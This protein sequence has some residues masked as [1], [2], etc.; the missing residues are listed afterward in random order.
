MNPE[1]ISLGTTCE[2]NAAFY[3][4]CIVSNFTT[5][6][7]LDFSVQAPDVVTHMR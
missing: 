4:S 2:L 7:A 6:L 3:T 5:S 1:F